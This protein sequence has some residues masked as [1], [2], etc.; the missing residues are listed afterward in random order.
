MNLSTIYSMCKRKTQH[1][2]LTPMSILKQFLKDDLTK[3]DKNFSKICD[4][5]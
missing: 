1:Q 4:N 2:K 5:T 3:T